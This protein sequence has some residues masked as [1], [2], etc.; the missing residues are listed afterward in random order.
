MET[1]TQPTSTKNLVQKLQEA[2]KEPT[3]N[4]VCHL[5]AMR[6]RGRRVITVQAFHDTLNEEGFKVDKEAVDAVFQT[7]ATLGLGTLDHHNN[8]RIRSL[9][10]ITIQ[11]QSI[12]KAALGG[13]TVLSRAK[14]KQRL[15]PLILP[16][17]KMPQKVVEMPKLTA[18]KQVK[19]PFRASAKMTVTVQLGERKISFDIP[20]VLLENDFAN[21]LEK[22]LKK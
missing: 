10:N 7:L 2:A 3:F 4:A 22:E 15:K 13:D 17:I 11:L 6:E 18:R 8:G 12:G 9:K 5:F 20:A 21:S 14:T 1:M 19:N 16:N